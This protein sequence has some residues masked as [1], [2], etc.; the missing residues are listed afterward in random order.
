[1]KGYTHPPAAEPTFWGLVA[2][3]LMAA[4]IVSGLWLMAGML[5][6]LARDMPDIVE[7]A[8]A[9]RAA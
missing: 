4:L 1:M 5:T 2:L 6:S 9:V 8:E 7:Q 3:L